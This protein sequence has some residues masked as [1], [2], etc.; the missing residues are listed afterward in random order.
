MAE[1]K[2]NLTVLASK[3]FLFVLKY[4]ACLFFFIDTIVLNDQIAKTII[5]HFPSKSYQFQIPLEKF[6]DQNTY[7]SKGALM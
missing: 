6:Y 2:L 3:N 4:K 7:L 1:T 5:I